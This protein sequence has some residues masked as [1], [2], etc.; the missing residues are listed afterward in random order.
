MHGKWLQSLIPRFDH[1]R[2]YPFFPEEKVYLLMNKPR[3]RHHSTADEREKKNRGDL[4]PEKYGAT[5][6]TRSGRLD[7]L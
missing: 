5:V 3:S 2:V 7:L 6:S 1:D 4:L